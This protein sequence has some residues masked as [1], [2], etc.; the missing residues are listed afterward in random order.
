[1]TFARFKSISLHPAGRGSRLGPWL[2]LAGVLA[3]L[4]AVSYQRHLGGEV[5]AREAQLSEMRV[6]SR[7]APALSTQESDTPGCAIKSKKANGVLQRMNVPWGELCCHRV[8]REWQYR[9]A[10]GAT[11]RTQPQRAGGGEARDLPAALAY[12]AR[13]ERTGRLRDVVLMTHEVKDQAAGPAGSLHTQRSLA[14]GPMS[15]HA[16]LGR[17]GGP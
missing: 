5:A 4:A 10:G 16:N 13:L 6:A 15:V 8:G 9:A 11:G 12:L 14:G 2:P 7:S 3:A 17:V 1:M